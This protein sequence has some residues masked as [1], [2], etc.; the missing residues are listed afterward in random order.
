MSIISSSTGN[1]NYPII[2]ASQTGSTTILMD[3]GGTTYYNPGTD[4]LTVPTIS[5]SFLTGSLFGTA[6]NAVS[7]SWAPSSTAVS[8]SW[9]SQSLS[10]SYLINNQGFVNQSLSIA[11][12]IALG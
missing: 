3:T 10:S 9:A 5:S 11:Y 2:F 7:A 1:V 6:S 8:A 12:A 4:T